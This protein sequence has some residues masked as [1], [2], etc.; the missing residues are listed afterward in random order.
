MKKLITILTLLFGLKTFGCSCI[1][2]IS[3][4]TP[5]DLIDFK[6]IFECRPISVKSTGNKFLYTVVISK[7]YWGDRR[8][9][10][11]V[12]TY[13]ERSMC[14][15]TLELNETYLIYAYG[16][17]TLEINSCGPS[18]QLTGIKECLDTGS[19]TDSLTTTINGLTKKYSF[20]FIK[21]FAQK[22]NDNEIKF[23]DLISKTTTGKLITKFSNGTTSG[24]INL[25]DKKLNGSSIFYYP[26]GKLKA[27]GSLKDNSMEGTWTTYRF[28]NYKDSPIYF[29]RTGKYMN[30]E[31]RGK[32]KG[33]IILGTK[34][35]Y[36]S[37]YL[38]SLD[39][40]YK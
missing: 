39:S 16:D 38:G 11:Q 30:N 8:D 10:V 34:K 17:K 28:V 27:T 23:L 2:D 32:W 3:E 35:D 21:A 40:D 12:S 37:Y 26:N 31:M 29:S 14:G 9:T 15:Y 6:N 33:K 19:P 25:V 18:R 13:Q 7:T 36:E 22:A 20:A 24:E 5:Y 1:Y 4:F